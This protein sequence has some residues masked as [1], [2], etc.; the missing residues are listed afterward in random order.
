M[1]RGR[2]LR[3][4]RW[5]SGR[6]A[7]ARAAAPRRPSLWRRLARAVGL[8]FAGCLLGGYALVWAVPPLRQLAAETIITS[9]HSAAARLVT[10]PAQYRAMLYAWKHP[11]TRHVVTAVA[12]APAS[13]AAASTAPAKP[14][15]QLIPISGSTYRG[16][17]FLVRHPSWVHV[18]VTPYI[19]RVG[20][21]TSTFGATTPGAIAAINGG[22]FEDAFGDGTGG[23]P[24]G[25][26]ASF[27]HLT[28]YPNPT[29]GYVIGL[30]TSGQL[31]VGNW[32]LAQ[33]RALGIRDAVVFQPLL[34]VQGQPQITHGDGGWG[35]APRTA[36]GQRADGT[37]IFTIID[38][39][40]PSSLGATLLQVQNLMLAEGAVTAVN[41]DGGSSTTLW[42]HGQLVNSPCCSPNGQRYIADAFVV[43]PPQGAASTTSAS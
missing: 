31:D 26:V 28:D 24:V 35:I 38:G 37:L 17:V 5:R 20:E 41:L 14:A 40:Q 21:Q 25:V 10:T 32:T 34:V 7:P 19:G 22:G 18:V 4:V 27:G 33:S 42:Y 8:G 6:R 1:L 9:G 12:P 2:K 30:N 36:L 11:P 39:R 29:G 16:W 3:R 43:I 23:L 13:S 15:V